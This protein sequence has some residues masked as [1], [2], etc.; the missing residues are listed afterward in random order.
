MGTPIYTS[1]VIR[2][3]FEGTV[4]ARQWSNIVHYKF[5]GGGP[6]VGDLTTMGNALVSAWASLM[7]AL[8][9]GDTELTGVKLT[10]LTSAL[11]AQT[12]V[13]AGLV[14][15]RAGAYL[16]ASASVLVTY[17]VAVRYRGGHPRNYLSVGVQ[18]DLATAQTW[19]TDFR[20]TTGAAWNELTATPVGETYGATS[21]TTFGMVSLR[22]ELVPRMYGVYYPYTGPGTA[23]VD[24]GSIRRRVRGR[25]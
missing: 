14:G 23:Q 5:S 24:L 11:G 12:T 17:D 20:D 18:A 8:Q 13:E 4:G 10:D 3:A 21:I 9:D 6:S 7:N 2:V 15:G 19:S 16:P 22:T 1:D 25:T